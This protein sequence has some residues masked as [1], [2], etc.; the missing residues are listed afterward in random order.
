ME[1]IYGLIP[2]MI[3]MGLIAV[4][5]FFWAAK[6]GQFDDLQGEAHRILMDDDLDDLEEVDPKSEAAQTQQKVAEVDVD[7]PDEESNQSETRNG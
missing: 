6:S 2:G 1:V 5:V 3:A 7:S 4:V